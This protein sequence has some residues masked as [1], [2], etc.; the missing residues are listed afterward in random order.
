MLS[1]SENQDSY[2]VTEGQGVCGAETQDEG[3]SHV[4]GRKERSGMAQDFITI[5]R[6]ALNLKSINC[7]FLVFPS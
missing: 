7:L 4:P 1:R 2:Y 3:V 6:T 5:L